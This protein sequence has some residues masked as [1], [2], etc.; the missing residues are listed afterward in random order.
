MNLSQKKGK[1]KKGKKAKEGRKFV[2]RDVPSI[3]ALGFV[4]WFLVFRRV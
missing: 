4:L 3:L 1:E 2:L